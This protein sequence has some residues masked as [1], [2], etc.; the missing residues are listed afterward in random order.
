MMIKREDFIK[1]IT[2]S[3]ESFSVCAILGPRQC[4]KT[5]LAHH[6]VQTIN[7]NAFFF[8]L[9]DPI[10]LDQ[11]KQPKT[12]LD[13]LSG[14]IIID[15]IQRQPDLFP[16]L[17]V[18]SDYSD[19]KFLI[20][21]SAS[22]ELLRQSSESLTGRIEYIELTPFNLDETQDFEKLWL[23]GGFPK[24]Y[25]AKSYVTSLKWRKN[26]LTSF[27]ERDLPSLGIILNPSTM[28]HLW[29]LLS[30][31]HGQL[32]NY[33]DIGRSLGVSDMTIR[34]YMEILSQTFMIRLLQPWHENISKR[35]V[36]A[37]KVY[38]RD[39]GLLHSLLG[40]QMHDWHVHPKR[41]ASFEGFVI[42]EII[43]KFG[44]SC[45][46]FFWRTQ[47]GA[48]LDL[49]LIKDGKKYGFEIKSVDAPSLSKSMQIALEDLKLEH[50]YVVTPSERT[51]KKTEKVTILGIKSL[52]KFS[53]EKM[54]G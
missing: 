28:R 27:I 8:D 32:L 20:L 34:R 11:L 50:L 40:V 29:M 23:Y 26:Y 35:Q 22:G 48:E 21:G 10:H 15:E 2:E 25:L 7:Q 18:L 41:G 1:S 4:G 24:S 53:I 19:K 13:P 39:S 42:E 43:R 3:F 54:N 6:Y 37:P 30:H 31:F 45:D 9:E 49:L 44:S 12:T 16:Y 52:P 51:Y 38:I 46:Y 36:K 47:V 14:L 17:R 5:T 33:S